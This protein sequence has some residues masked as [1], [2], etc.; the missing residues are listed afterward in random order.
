MKNEWI[1]FKGYLRAKKRT[2]PGVWRLKE[3]GFLI[4]GRVRSD[5]TGKRLEVCHAVDTDDPAAAYQQLQ[6]ELRALQSGPAQTSSRMRFA[7]FA[8]SL[9]EERVLT[10]EIRSAST[11]RGWTNI[12]GHLLAPYPTGWGDVYLDAM[13]SA[14]VL[15]WR[16]RCA[17]LVAQEGTCLACAGKGTVERQARQERCRTCSG[18]GQHQYGPRTINQWFAKFQTIMAAA[19]ARKLIAEDPT[20]GLK[21]LPTDQART[22]TPEEPNSMTPVEVIRFLDHC[23]DRYPQ[24]Y[25]KLVLGMV[26]GRRPSELRPLRK[27]GPTPD[28]VFRADGTALL[29]IRR[30]H[31]E[32]AE[33][34]DGTKTGEDLEIEL[35]PWLADVLRWH[36]DRQEGAQRDSELLFPAGDG[37][38]LDKSCLYR[39]FA[40]LAHVA[41]IEKHLTPRALRRSY[42]D[43][44]R[45]AKTPDVITRSISGHITEDMQRHYSTVSGSEQR[46]SIERVG[47]LLKLPL[48]GMNRGMKGAGPESAAAPQPAEV[49]DPSGDR[50]LF[51]EG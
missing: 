18:S 28:V 5:K 17:K 51:R 30:S 43:L 19:K 9:F 12:L 50:L 49:R 27:K 39:R 40:M 6:E 48:R 22:Y 42:Q 33:V 16:K 47:K 7:E 3:G 8:P 37:E 15:E 41:K 38:L 14:D 34:M 36:I 2:L 25:A 35:P 1:K 26:T 32:G 11:R 24:W 46:E 23:W 31:S 4:R 29:L 20:E 13:T 44:Q 10:G 45:A 21:P